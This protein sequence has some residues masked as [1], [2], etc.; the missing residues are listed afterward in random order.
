MND[1]IIPL[2]PNIVQIL[3][4]LIPLHIVVKVGGDAVKVV[5]TVLWA[6]PKDVTYGGS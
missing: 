2:Q 6:W 4:K 3:T 5:F 1:L